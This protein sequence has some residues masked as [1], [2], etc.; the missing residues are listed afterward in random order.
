MSAIIPVREAG[1]TGL[2]TG[3]KNA[4][5]YEDGGR[6][7]L[8]NDELKTKYLALPA[9]SDDESMGHGDTSS[10]GNFQTSVM[11]S[12]KKSEREMDIFSERSQ[13]LTQ[14]SKRSGIS[15]Y[16]HSVLSKLSKPV[17]LPGDKLLRAQAE[18]KH[19]K[20]NLKEIED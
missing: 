12:R 20:Q 1:Q 7:E 4:Y 10:V 19:L 8:I 14:I 18:E 6:M 13:Q 11:G 9:P 16:S 3:Q 15:S 5:D 17:S 2:S